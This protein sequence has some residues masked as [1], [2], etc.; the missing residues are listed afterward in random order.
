MHITDALGILE[1]YDSEGF[2]NIIVNIFDM[3]LEYA[4]MFL[5]HAL[6]QLKP[7][8][9]LKVNA[10]VHYQLIIPTCFNTIYLT[11]SP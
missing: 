10:P 4:P 3:V 5:P 6:P 1:N 7:N 8:L 2:H 11:L 9:F